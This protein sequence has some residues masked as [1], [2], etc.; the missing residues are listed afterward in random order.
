MV[1]KSRLLLAHQQACHQY[2]QVPAKGML[3][4]VRVVVVSL[5]PMAMYSRDRRLRIAAASMRQ[6]FV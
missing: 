3:A 6:S 1:A 4:R 5:P 2:V